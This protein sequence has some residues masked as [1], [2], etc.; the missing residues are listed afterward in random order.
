MEHADPT[1]TA[2]A[3][4]NIR[5]GQPIGRGGFGA[6]YRG[7]HVTLDVDVAV[8]IV[9]APDGTD[10]DR[11]LHEARLMA[12]LDHPNL[13]RIYDA[14]L[15]QRTLYLVLELMD[16][17][18]SSMRRLPPD[19]AVSVARQLLSGLQALHDARVLHR[20]V[21]PANCLIRSRDERVKL[22]DLGISVEQASRSERVYDTAGTLPFMAPELFDNPP[23]FSQAS[24]LYA[25]GLTLQCLL[26]DRDPF[27]HGSRTEVYAWIMSPARTST[28]VMRADLPASFARLVDRLCVPSIDQRTARA[29]D[30]LAA[31]GEVVGAGSGES[32]GPAAET[33]TQVMVGGWILG[34]ELYRSINWRGYAANHVSTGVAARVSLVQPHG[35]VAELGGLI[36]ESAER[37][38]QLRH[39][40]IIAILD[41]GVYQDRPFVVTEPQGQTMTALVKSAGPWDEVA[42]LDVAI[43]LADALV[44]LHRAG[45]VYQTLDPGSA[46]ITREARAAQLSWPM[47]CVPAGTPA[48][49]TEGRSRRVMVPKFAAPEVFGGSATVEPAVDLYAL[50]EVLYFLLAGRAAFDDTRTAQTTAEIIAAKWRAGADIR[51]V[52]AAITA[53]TARLIARLTD[54]DPT[55]RPPTAV[56]ARDELAAIASRIRGGA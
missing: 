55:R 10:I 13:L 50:G 52:R 41:W 20:D 49:E 53:P 8:K 12:R 2:P 11:S 46:V 22:A 30:A 14:G 56:D 38:S 39:P 5:L 15:A 23:R 32:E 28:G 37:A 43:G 33:V 21:K 35:P 25:L 7:R 9:N 1:E 18:C 36:L 26:F 4:P 34:D 48:A 51:R 17:S 42:A 19:R 29:S 47:F 6:V 31:L 27:P 54:P 3:I 45:L 16:G 40:G 24:D 44:Y